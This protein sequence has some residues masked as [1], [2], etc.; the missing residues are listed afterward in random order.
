VDVF[1]RRLRRKLGAN[2]IETFRNVGYA[3]RAG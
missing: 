2:A 3:V 1:V